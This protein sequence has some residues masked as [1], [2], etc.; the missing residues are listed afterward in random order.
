[1]QREL[2]GALPARGAPLPRRRR[3]RS[4]AVRA[5]TLRAAPPVARRLF[6]GR[7]T[8]CC[9]SDGA[10]T[11]FAV[12]VAE[13]ELD[14]EVFSGPVRPAADARPARGGRPARGRARRR[15]RHVPRLPRGARRARPRGRDRVP[16]A[17][18]RAAGAEVAPACCRART[19]SCSTSSP[20]RRPR[21]CSRG[22]S[23][24]A[25]TGAAAEHLAERLAGEHG[26]R[27]RS[28]PL[29]PFL[30]RADLERVRGRLRPGAA[31]RG[32]RRAAAHAARRSSLA[33]PHDPAGHASPSASRT[34]ARLLRRGVAHL[35]RGRARRRPRDGRGDAVRAARALQAGRGR[36]GR[37][38]SRSA[39]ID[40]RRGARGRRATED[41]R[42]SELA[43]IAR[44]AAVPVARARAARPTWPRPRGRGRRGRRGA[45]GAARGIRA[46]ASA[47][48]C[49]ASVAGGWTLVSAPDAE[50]AA[51]RLLA[52]PRTPPLTP[53]QAE[54]LAIVAYLQPVSRP[55][56]TRIRGVSAD[57]AAG[58]LLER[59]LIEESGR[60]Q[61]GAVALPHDAAVPEALRPRV[62]RRPAR[63]RSAW[64]PSPE[65][66]GRRCATPAQGRRR[67]AL[68]RRCRATSPR[69]M[70]ARRPRLRG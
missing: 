67:R 24:R 41:A 45:R 26:H 55:E 58:T 16:R 34:C 51:R 64:D 29:P 61:F 52:K 70:S 14:L 62:A 66:G 9:S 12:T 11:L 69:P 43:R 2:S 49:C 46:R 4:A 33:P 7:T 30:R 32:D 38:T 60:S 5:G 48:S 35:R 36:R 63:S 21:S 59:G 44:G 39:P 37:R 42:M 3:A 57:S 65:R 53:A 27:F 23:R 20:A 19:R 15:R 28:A 25:A 68:A 17:D 10:A 8:R 40:D 6:T 47:A 22:C 18:R 1:M 54:T 56:I 13:L 50:E 31:G